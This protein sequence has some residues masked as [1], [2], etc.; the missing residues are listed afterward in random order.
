VNSKQR[1]VVELASFLERTQAVPNTEFNA[2]LE[3]FG[4]ARL[5]NQVTLTQIL[6]RPEI[7]IAQLRALFPDIPAHQADVDAQVEIQIKYQGYVARQQEI[8]GRFQKMEH[9]RLPENTDYS[10]ISGLSREVCEKLSRIRPRSLG[11]AA[12]IPGITPAAISLL[13]FYIKT[14]SA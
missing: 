1:A 11:Q 3:S 5:R 12:R 9:A 2:A 7:S 6:R 4:T 13:S 10:R 14:R 8:V